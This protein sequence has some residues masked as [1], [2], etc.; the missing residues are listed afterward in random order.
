MNCNS[1]GMYWAAGRLVAVLFAAGGLANTCLAG[2]ERILYDVDF[3]GPPHVVG[4]TPAFGF[5]SFPRN[6]PTS[7]GQIFFPSGSATVETSFGPLANR[8]VKLKALDGTPNDPGK[9]GGADLQFDLMDPSLASLD[10][11]HASVDVV[12]AQLRTASGLGIFFDASSIH[13]VQ[14]WPDAGIRIIDATGVN[15]VVGFYS[16]E[17]TYHV[18]MTFDRAAVEWS[19]A[20][21]GIPVYQG[22]AADTDMD[23][24]RIAM[25][26]GDSISPAVAFVDN[27]RVSADVPEPATTAVVGSALGCIGLFARRRRT[28]YA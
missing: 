13:S 12:P 3:D 2:P 17:S 18:Q 7:G 19:A 24:F 4:A 21:N 9:L 20:I 22:P 25:T 11:F 26:T 28:R 27:I 6:T 23:R 15:S 16:P 14:F 5:G 10:R 8:P 1:N